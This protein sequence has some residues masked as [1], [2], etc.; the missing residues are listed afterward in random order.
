MSKTIL[1][2]AKEVL[3]EI[4]SAN[5]DGKITL[6]EAGRISGAVIHAA[7]ATVDALEDRQAGFSQVVEAA[8]AAFDEI[9]APLDL[10][11]IP[12]WLEVQAKAVIRTQI[13]P[14]IQAMYEALDAAA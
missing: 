1:E 6:A 4:Q 12:N 2:S 13:R 5:A 11:G 8:E 9:I 7:A 3:G 10:Q 14:A